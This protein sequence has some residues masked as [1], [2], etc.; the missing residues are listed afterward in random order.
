VVNG[1][2]TSALIAL[3]AQ[4]TYRIVVVNT[5][6]EG[7]GPPSRG[8]RL[9][10]GGTVVT[11]PAPTQVSAWWTGQLPPGLSLA[12]HWNA[13]ASGANTVDMYEVSVVWQDGD[14]HGGTYDQTVSGQAFYAYFAVD[15]TS[16]WKI[17]VRAH[18][19]AGWGAW[20]TPIVIGGV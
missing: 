18:D 3:A 6:L 9:F 7:S 20:S 14:N 13:S 19:A 1:P 2:A 12:V 15:N 8:I 17:E 5:D 4:T 10:T 16:D 11:P